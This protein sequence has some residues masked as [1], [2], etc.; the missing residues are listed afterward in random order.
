MG[1]QVNDFHEPVFGDG[2]GGRARLRQRRQRH[3][4][5]VGAGG[6]DGL[7]GALRVA[8]EPDEPQRHP[9]PHWRAQ[10]GAHRQRL[11]PPSREQRDRP[12]AVQRLR[13]PILQQVPQANCKS[14]N[15]FPDF[16]LNF[17]LNKLIVTCFCVQKYKT[18]IFQQNRR[19]SPMTFIPRY[20]CY[21]TISVE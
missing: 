10:P 19:T 9:R 21:S 1:S 8:G 20:Q 3:A 4:D 15:E 6:A 2:Y 11:A 5:G 13:L 7:P 18:H 16:F 14:A 12:H 17:N